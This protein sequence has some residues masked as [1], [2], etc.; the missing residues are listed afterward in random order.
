MAKD[1]VILFLVHTVSFH[2]LAFKNVP[3]NFSVSVFLLL[4]LPPSLEGKKKTKQVF[5]FD[6]CNCRK[7]I[8]GH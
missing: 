6:A 5:H 4:F 3:F 1:P 2:I 8:H 7:G